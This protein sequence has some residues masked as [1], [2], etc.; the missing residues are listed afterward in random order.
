MSIAVDDKQPIVRLAN[1]T[2][3]K[4]GGEEAQTFLSNQFT[5]NLNSLKAGY[6]SLSTWC[7]P[8]GRVLYS[9]RMWQDDGVFYILL[10]GDSDAFIKRLRMFV[11][12]AK[13]TVDVVPDT[14]FFG[15]VCNNC[16]DRFAEL[17]ATDNAFIH[18]AGHT[19]IKVPGSVKRFLI[20]TDTTVDFDFTDDASAKELWTR[21]D[22]MAG[23][24]EISSETTEQFLPQMLDMEHLGGLSFQKGCYPGQEIVA[25]VKYRGELK[26]SLYKAVIQTNQPVLPGM[27]LQVSIDKQ[28]STAG[29]VVNAAEFGHHRYLVLAVMNIAS[30]QNKHIRLK[31]DPASTFC[32][33]DK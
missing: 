28:I 27:D 31:S 18:T 13:V 19:I 24:P 32:L 12:R 6:S 20:V 22:I 1:Y 26:K 4:I 15:L 7:S 21:H 8:K 23:I 30:V 11:L 29:T 9:F 16:K 25:R 14:Q 2:L 5:N 3:I 10:A 33:F 17:P